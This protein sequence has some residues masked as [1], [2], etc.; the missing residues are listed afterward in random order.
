VWRGTVGDVDRLG[1]R[2]RVN[3]AGILP[4]TAEITVGAFEAL[5]LRP[6]E[7]TFA[8]VKATEI[9]VYPA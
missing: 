1:D 4:L 6:G 3:I 8:S 2:V 9:E 7:E 5:D